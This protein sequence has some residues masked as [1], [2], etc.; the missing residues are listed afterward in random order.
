MNIPIAPFRVLPLRAR[1]LVM[2]VL[3]IAL[4][5]VSAAQAQDA[6]APYPAMAP[7]AQYLMAD[8]SA[9]IALARSAAPDAISR[10]ATVLVMGKTGYQTAVVG[11]NGFTCL[12]ER[13]WMS[14][15]D[16]PDFWNPKLRGP[17]CYNPA[18]VRSILPY[19][20]FR[21][22]WVLAG[23]SK[24]QLHARIVAAVASHELPVPEPGA[25]SFMMA[26]GGYLGD[27]VGH[28][29]PHLMFHIPKTDGAT[30][31]ANL[32]GSP[33]MLNEDYT[34]MPEPETIFLVPVGRWSDGTPAHAMK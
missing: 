34:D 31:G 8:P 13:S 12:V 22:K 24:A 6:Q 27:G 5:S 30:W 10:D 23:D 25:M 21:T 7:L 9:E 3:P 28:W 33:V 29:H 14:P 19:T 15:F 1:M 4:C 16:S 2:R 11:K 32:P 20:L 18:A 26:K 17:V